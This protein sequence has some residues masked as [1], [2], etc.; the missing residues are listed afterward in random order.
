MS[1]PAAF[2]PCLLPEIPRPRGAVVCSYLGCCARPVQVRGSALCFRRTWRG[3]LDKCP[4]FTGGNLEAQRP[5]GSRCG[6]RARIWGALGLKMR[7][8]VRASGLCRSFPYGDPEEQIRTV[9]CLK[10]PRKSA[11]EASLARGGELF[12]PT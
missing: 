4:R 1:E 8:R 12:L 11:A 6:C 10:S 9:I 3:T 7:L 2:P 5:V